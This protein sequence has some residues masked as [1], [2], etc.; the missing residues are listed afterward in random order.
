[1]NRLSVNKLYYND[2][3]EFAYF[4]VKNYTDI[5]RINQIYS[6]DIFS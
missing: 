1:M 3:F 6:I 4:K 2:T 5:I